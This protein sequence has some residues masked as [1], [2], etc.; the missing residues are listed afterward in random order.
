MTAPDLPALAHKKSW[1]L[2]RDLALLQLDSKL[3]RTSSLV[4]SLATTIPFL[5]EEQ[6]LVADLVVEADLVV[7]L[8][9]EADS[10]VDLVVDDLVVD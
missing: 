3:S 2:L 4:K 7:D 6:A 1:A 9:V 8:V 5:E 10:V